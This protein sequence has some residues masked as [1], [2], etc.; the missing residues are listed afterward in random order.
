MSA[1]KRWCYTVNNYTTLPDFGDDCEYHV[2]GK[3]VGESG[4]P[5]LQ[6]FV[7]FTGRGKR[8]TALKK[9][10]P[11]AHWERARGTN[12]QAS[13]YCK[14]DGVFY[15]VGVMPPEKG[16]AGG[17]ATKKRY[18]DAFAIACSGNIVDIE[19]DLLIRH[20]RTFKQIKLDNIGMIKPMDTTTGIWIYGR[21]GIG[22][23]LYARSN[24]PDFYDKP[25]N[26]WWDGYKD[27]T[28]VIIDDFD[29]NHACL[30]HHLKR[31]ADHYAFMAETKGGGIYIR[32]E[33][34]IVTS[35]HTIRD[36][37]HDDHTVVE[38]L[39]RRFKILDFN[40]NPPVIAEEP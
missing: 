6:G 19:K 35:Q 28:A 22:K 5:H 33:V 3:E 20:Y 27:Q 8:L 34:I 11:T 37:W 29:N 9:L 2:Y 4:T 18:E 39:E 10:I 38:A 17:A 30:G 36:I 24:W 13:A 26:K 16:A 1:Y 7:I 31:W 21:S 32:P 15:E 25:C 12:A 23:S 40:K 14:K